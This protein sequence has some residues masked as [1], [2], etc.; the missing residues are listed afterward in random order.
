[1]SDHHLVFPN[2]DADVLADVAAA[3][4]LDPEAESIRQARGLS[5][6]VPTVPAETLDLLA[7]E[8]GAAVA[9]L[10]LEVRTRDGLTATI[11][12][13]TLTAPGGER[14]VRQAAYDGTTGPDAALAPLGTPAAPA[15][16]GRHD[17]TLGAG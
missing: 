12:Q 7:K 4:Q 3:C 14:S 16:P 17:F 11:A 13:L 2:V 1:M 9:A 5:V 15:T 6:S 8:T 10:V